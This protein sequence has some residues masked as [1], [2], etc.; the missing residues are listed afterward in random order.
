MNMTLEEVW[1]LPQ[2][3]HQ[4]QSKIGIKRTSQALKDQYGHVKKIDDN[5]TYLYFHDTY[6]YCI[7]NLRW[8]YFSMIGLNRL[9]IFRQGPT[10]HL[11]T[12][13]QVILYD[14]YL[15]SMIKH[16]TPF[17]PSHTVCGLLYKL[18]ADY[19]DTPP[20]SKMKLIY[21]LFSCFS[22]FDGLKPD[23]CEDFSV[24]YGT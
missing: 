21:K 12:A 6:K 3:R 14:T 16:A 22:E 11:I 24:S 13:V 5:S 18:F 23:E 1:N 4:P 15:I 17:M 8:L 7:N 19:K 9:L 20:K 2:S 10:C